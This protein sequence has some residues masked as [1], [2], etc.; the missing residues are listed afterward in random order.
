MY[1]M[2]VAF[3]GTM[4]FCHQTLGLE[5]EFPATNVFFFQEIYL[6]DGVLGVHAAKIEI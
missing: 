5:E 2:F 6:F 3:Q 4:L 1:H